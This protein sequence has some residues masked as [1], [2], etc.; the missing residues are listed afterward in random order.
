MGNQQTGST[1]FCSRGELYTH[2]P[3][4]T[5]FKFDPET[6]VGYCIPVQPKFQ[7]QRM[8]RTPQQVFPKQQQ[9]QEEVVEIPLSQLSVGQW[10]IPKS[11]FE[12]ENQAEKPELRKSIFDINLP[13]LREDGEI[14]SSQTIENRLPDVQEEIVDYSKNDLYTFDG[15]FGNIIINMNGPVLY[16]D[17]TGKQH[18]EYFDKE[19]IEKIFPMGISFGGF[20]RSIWFKDGVSRDE[21]FEMMISMPPSYKA[22]LDNPERYD[23]AENEANV[24]ADDDNMKVFEGINETNVIVHSDNL[25][26]YTDLDKNKHCVSY[27]KRSIAKCFPKGI[28]FG[29]LPRT[30]WF[31]D[32]MERDLCFMLMQWNM[33]ENIDAT[34]LESPTQEYTGLYGSVVLHSDSQIGYTSLT[35]DN[36]KCFYEPKD[37]VATFPK[38]IS[39]GRLPKTIWFGDVEEREKCIEAMR[40]K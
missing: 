38:G 31:S 20:T 36:I 26:L 30:I 32:E 8:Q 28:C 24:L 13:C 15:V 39:F 9:V 17:I 22:V 34:P 6:R 14:D 18:C 16:T 1:Q 21:A 19:T 29:G 2:R 25:V 10:K 37:I 40:S 33:N 7:V 11:F 4:M 35:G 12:I 3:Q 5:R 23:L 27:N